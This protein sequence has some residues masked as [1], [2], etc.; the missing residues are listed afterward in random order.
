[1]FDLNGRR[2][3][4]AVAESLPRGIYIIRRTSN[5]GAVETRKIII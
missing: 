3:S 1:L 2:L 5:N 4:R